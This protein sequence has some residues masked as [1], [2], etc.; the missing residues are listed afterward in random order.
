MQT[1][2]FIVSTGR[3]GSTMLSRLLSQHPD[4]T[5]LSELFNCL[6]PWAFTK[7]P[8]DGPNL[9][10]VLS[11]PRPHTKLSIK[12]L[13]RGIKID[14]FR[15]PVERLERFRTKG[16]PPLLAMTLPELSDDPD[17]LHEDL[18]KF[19]EALP[20]D[21]LGVQYQR[22]FEWLTKRMGRRI[23]VERSGTSLGFLQPMMH[24]FPNAKFVHI[25]RD[26]REMAYSASRFPPMRFGQISRMLQA[27]IGK[28]LYEKLSENDLARV[29]DEFKNLIAQNFDVD[30]FMKYPIPIERF[31]AM[32]ND[33]ITSSMP[34]LAKLPPERVM[35]IS[36][37]AV[38]E[39]PKL[40]LQRFLWFLDSNLE[41]KRWLDKVIPQVKAN[42]LKW[43]T[44]PEDQRKRLEAACAPGMEILGRLERSVLSYPA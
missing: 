39:N 29:P 43:T 35:H 42:P 16:I 17:A 2:L 31:G 38:L 12:L 26:G 28:N 1:P 22:I 7:H 36:Y 21:G 5:S 11:E 41:R 23:W 25:Y 27:K 34:L 13:E 15:Y 8:A 40:E 6:H 44:L 19:V 9:W 10:H 18:G 20:M 24:F 32:W 33:M 37:E 30:A 14:E 4:V 3:C